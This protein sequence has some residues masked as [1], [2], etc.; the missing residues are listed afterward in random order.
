MKLNL[1]AYILAG[2][3]IIFAISTVCEICRGDEIDDIIPHLIK[4]ES[5]G[6]SNAVGDNG[7]S[8]GLMQINVNGALKEW[9]K[10]CGQ[11]LDRE[12]LFEK[13]WNLMV[14]EFYLRRLKEHYLKDFFGM[15]QNYNR[16]THRKSI[17][18]GYECMLYWQYPNDY[19]YQYINLNA[20]KIINSVKDYETALILAAYNWGIG[21]LKKA[22]YDLNKAPK[23]TKRYIRNIMRNYKESK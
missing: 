10:V 22:N 18:A 6:D 19:A 13:E 5:G 21:N 7:N 14:G 15:I 11:E 8:I 2:L 17:K 16:T 23:S 9:N 12:A 1:I 4:Y 3:A 20:F